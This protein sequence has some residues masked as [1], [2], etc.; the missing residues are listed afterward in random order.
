MHDTNHFPRSLSGSCG[1]QKRYIMLSEVIEDLEG[2]SDDPPTATDPSKDLDSKDL[3]SKDLNKMLSEVIEDLEGA[4]DDPPTATDPSKDL[5]SKDLKSKDLN[6]ML[7]EV[8]EDLEG[9]DEPSKDPE[10]SK[11][12]DL[13]DL[14]ATP[15]ETF[16][17]I[18]T[19]SKALNSST[20][21]L[22]SIQP[23]H[24]RSQSA[25]SSRSKFVKKSLKHSGT[26]LI[27][28]MQLI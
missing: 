19:G 8:I 11:D 25:M 7:S 10:R 28:K 13:K 22:L 17:K 2:A 21:C 6:K 14:P 23:Q 16:K 4:S 26:N 3:K 24:S 12:L 18:G 5:D 20:N 1:K 15:P 27:R 9:G